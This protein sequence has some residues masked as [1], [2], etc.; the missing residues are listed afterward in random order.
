[1]TPTDPTSSSS[2]PPTTISPPPQ[3]PQT[4]ELP[5]PVSYP[6]LDPPPP[7]SSPTPLSPPTPTPIPTPLPPKPNP[8]P[9]PIPAQPSFIL[10]PITYFSNPVHILLQNSNGPCPLL[11]LANVLILRNALTLPASNRA[12]NTI[13]Y[14]ELVSLIGGLALDR[15]S[16]SSSSS[17]TSSAVVGEAA[18]LQ[19]VIDLLPGLSQGLDV[20]PKFCHGVTGYEYTEAL[21]VFD[22]FGVELVH[23][24]LLDPSDPQFEMFKNLSYN[25]LV[26]L[27]ISADTISSSSSPPAPSS[28]KQSSLASMNA[29][30][31]HLAR[32]FLDT[33]SHQ[34]T[35]PGLTSLHTHLPQNSTSVFFRNNHFAPLFKHDDKLLLLVTDQG[36]ANVPSVVWEVL[37]N[38]DGDTTY[39]DSNFAAP[40]VNDDYVRSYEATHDTNNPTNSDVQLQ[41]A[42]GES[43]MCR[44][45]PSLFP[46]PSSPFPLPPFSTHT[47]RF[48]SRLPPFRP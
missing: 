42:I 40:S 16:S 43:L 48:D 45:S 9:N 37:G 3:P 33:S 18:N 14:E 35:Y 20:N 10:K 31:G 26:E 36:Y 28:P 41:N 44:L 7:L 25:Q 39:V 23:G 38:I 46:L 2:P 17:S 21:T 8:N 19:S 34:L 47:F 32:S 29:V 4:D 6:S 1:M 13:T 5:P 12:T 15:Q 30:R 24:W 11:A 27:V 22:L